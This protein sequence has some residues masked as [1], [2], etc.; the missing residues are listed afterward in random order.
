MPA[1]TQPVGRVSRSLFDLGRDSST[2]KVPNIPVVT[3]FRTTLSLTIASTGPEKR[4]RR[5]KAALSLSRDAVKPRLVGPKIHRDMT[6]EECVNTRKNGPARRPNSGE[7]HKHIR[8][9]NL[10][11]EKQT[12]VGLSEYLTLARFNQYNRKTLPNGRVRDGEV[13]NRRSIVPPD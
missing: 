11:A 10:R 7:C 1:Q 13:V 6:L 2:L 5:K 3:K 9:N 12:S 4:M 8:G